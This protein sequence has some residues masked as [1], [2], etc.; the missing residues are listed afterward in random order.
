MADQSRQIKLAAAK[1]KLKEFQLKSSPTNGGVGA[2]KRRKMKGGGNEPLG[3]RHSLDNTCVNRENR[4]SPVTHLLEESSTELDTGFPFTGPTSTST[5]PVPN[6]E[7]VSCDTDLQ[8][9]NSGTNDNESLVEENRPLSSTESLRQ[10]SQ[11]LNGLLSEASTIYV[12]G[13][14]I[15]SPVNQKKLESRN[16]ELAAALD[17]SSLEISHLNTKLD[18]LTKQFQEQT[19]QLQ[20]ERKEFDQK[21]GREQG[22][23]REQLQVHIQTIGILVS[24]KSELQTALSYTQQAARQKTG[25]AEELSNRLQATRQRVSELERTLSSISTQQ[26]QLEKHHKELEKEKEDLRLDVYRLNNVSDE[27]KQQNSELI[28][29]LKLNVSQ[30]NTLTLELDELRKRLEMAD[31]ML[32]QF[33]S[34]SDHS[35]APQQIQLLLEEKHQL[36]AHSAQ[37]MESVVQL[38]TERDRYNEKIQEE[39][40]VWK[41]KTEQLLSQVVLVAEERDRRINQVQELEATIVELNNSTSEQSLQGK[42]QADPLSQG[43]SKRELFLQEALSSLQQE[44]E[45]L[46]IQYQAQLRDNEQ[47]SHMCLEL[48]ERVAE[49]ERHAEQEA[50]EAEDRRRMLDD[51]QSDKAT[52]SRA[53]AQNR[54][55]KDQLAELQNGFVKLTNENMELTSAIQ[56]EQHVKKEL[57][58]KMGQLQVD[59]HNFKEQLDHKSKESQALQEQRDQLLA[60]L[61]QYSAGYQNL[62]S[63]REELHQHYLQHSQLMDQLQHNEAKGQVQLEMNQKQLEQTLET[64][65][66]LTRDNQQLKTEVQE[67]NSSTLATPLRDQGDG[68]ESQLPQEVPQKSS[69]I[70]LPKDFENREEMVEMERDEMRS[71]LEKETSLHTHHQAAELS[72]GHQHHSNSH[73]YHLDYNH[74]LD[75]YG[76]DI[77]QR[78]DHKHTDLEGGVPVE[79]YEAL[80]VSTEKLQMRFTSL[81]QEKADLKDRME[82]L[83]HRCIQLSGETDTIGEYIALYQNQRAIMKQRHIEKEQCISILAQDKEEMKAKL[84]ELQDLVMRLVGERN[85]WYSRYLA[86]ITDFS[87]IANPNPLP[88]GEEAREDP[89]AQSRMELNRPAMEHCTVIDPASYPAPGFSISLTQTQVPSVE[90]IAPKPPHLLGEDVTACQI[91][92]L[93]QEIQNPQ[94]PT[95]SSP[96]LGANPCIPFFYRPD[97]QDEVKIL[98]I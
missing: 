83:E 70:I 19:D 49:L 73:D 27:A 69:S 61:Q 18:Q 91:L 56:S 47:L 90:L 64:L 78:N 2:K 5:K 63:E 48:E 45:V 89:F 30:N 53:L 6:S 82:E 14:R 21:F 28:E 94:G 57:A 9:C 74:C 39:G 51:V 72:I 50:G 25:D 24:E 12:N 11:Q 97:E 98:V 10:L 34:Q 22:A 76:H 31:T 96:F 16:D 23:M 80:R 4:G 8:H 40:Q 46:D 38:Q 15:P 88:G 54:T 52:I 95:R 37:L 26:K 44:K 79:V 17:S 36:V 67:L 62:A 92:K 75:D 35:N 32:Q 68:V 13:D 20:K 58:K 66:Q 86:T 93:L 60:Y 7:C 84:L 33:S 3:D 42:A 43:P 1:K 87:A 71:R 85:E 59:L 29:Q 81:M 55:L 77:K 65:E 41:D